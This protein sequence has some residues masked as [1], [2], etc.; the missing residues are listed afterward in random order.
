M[1][2]SS[3]EI[4]PVRP[5]SITVQGDQKM[6][7][8]SPI[9]IMVEGFL[10]DERSYVTKLERLLELKTKIE[11]DGSLCNDNLNRIFNSLNP[12]IDLQRRLLL[13]IEMTARKP[14]QIWASPFKAWC[15]SMSSIYGNFLTKEKWAREYIRNF[16]VEQQRIEDIDLNFALTE[17][18]RLLALPFQHL[19]KYS[20]FLLVRPLSLYLFSSHR[21]SHC[22]PCHAKSFTNPSQELIQQSKLNESPKHVSDSINDLQSVLRDINTSIRV[23]EA[24]VDLIARSQGWKNHKI[25]AF[26]NLL[27]FDILDI[28]IGDSDTANTV[29]PNSHQ[30]NIVLLA[31]ISSN[32]IN[33]ITSISLTEPSYAVRGIYGRESLDAIGSLDGRKTSNQSPRQN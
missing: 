9:D 7:D 19:P 17:F 26:G 2:T 18:L 21:C 22:T 14:L 20:E 4:E 23:Q 25:D 28:F 8:P 10:V 12:I 16:L 3:G 24:L 29:C 6:T 15:G 32:V 30:I 13:S 1:L 27:L 5:G 31:P 33:S 11:T